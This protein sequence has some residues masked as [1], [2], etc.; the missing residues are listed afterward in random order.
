MN[1]L[2]LIFTMLGERM[3]TELSQDEKP[4]T[5]TKSKSVAKRGGEVAGDAKKR[6]EK[7]LGR[8]VSTSKNYISNSEKNKLTCKKG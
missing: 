2:E 7:E 6:A 8:P 1:D 3:T 4:D 5:F